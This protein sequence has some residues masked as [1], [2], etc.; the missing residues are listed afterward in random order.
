MFNKKR[1]YRL[2]YWSLELLLVALLIFVCTQI[3]FIF[4]PIGIF[5]STIFCASIDR[6]FLILCAESLGQFAY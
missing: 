5:I 2:M 3:G 4:Q 6:R 1:R